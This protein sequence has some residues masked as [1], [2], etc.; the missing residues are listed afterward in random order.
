MSAQCRQSRK[1]PTDA[2]AFLLHAPFILL[3]I[4]TAE[5]LVFVAQR[6]LLVLAQI[7]YRA[8]TAK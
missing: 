8:P 7:Y 1:T 3:L 5:L 2:S 6:L 4:R